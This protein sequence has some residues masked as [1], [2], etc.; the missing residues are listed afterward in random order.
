MKLRVPRMPYAPDWEQHEWM[1]GW[2]DG[3]MH[4]WMDGRTDGRTDGWMDGWMDGWTDGRMDRW[5]DGRTD[6]SMD[7]WTDGRMDGWNTLSDCRSTH[8][9]VFISLYPSVY[10]KSSIFGDITLC[11]L[12]QPTFRRNS[13]C[14]LLSRWYLAWLILRP[15]RWRRHVPPKR[16]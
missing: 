3:W 9:P 10:V 1:D 15:W 6:G 2:P 11:S 16:R 7:G 13:A 14:Y 8:L 5:M 12:T 4:G